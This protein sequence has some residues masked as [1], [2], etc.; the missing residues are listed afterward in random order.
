MKLK[1]PKV[2]RCLDYSLIDAIDENIFENYVFSNNIEGNY[3]I[4]DIK[5]DSCIFKN[6]DFSNIELI[7]VELIDVIF[8]NCDL[9]NKSFD[10]KMLSRVKFINCKM[11]E[12]F[13]LV[14][15]IILIYLVLK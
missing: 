10:F 5:I 4:K 15:V 9:S 2:N 3:K 11:T 8:E 14:R 12:N 7:D 1:S 13:Y 6:I